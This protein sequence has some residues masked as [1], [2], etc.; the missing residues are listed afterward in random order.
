LVLI[1]LGKLDEDPWI[2]GDF[3]EGDLLLTILRI[4][5]QFWSEHPSE[6][7]R[8]T[9]VMTRLQRRREI[10]EAELAPA[11]LKIFGGA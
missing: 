7:Q 3:F 5:D 9:G 11:W 1:A 8:L 10:Y 4:P 2:Q 6:L